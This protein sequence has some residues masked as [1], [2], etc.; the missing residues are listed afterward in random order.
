MVWMG[1]IGEGVRGSGI[2]WRNCQGEVVQGRVVQA[3]NKHEESLLQ[4]SICF[5]FH[6]A[7][8]TS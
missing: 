6:K 3:L 1:I 2:A 8:V 7:N 4:F 5:M